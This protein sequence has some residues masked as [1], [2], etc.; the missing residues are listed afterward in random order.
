MVVDTAVC[1][2]YVTNTAN[3]RHQR[4]SSERNEKKRQKE[5]KY[6]NRVF[7]WQPPQLFLN[8]MAG[9]E[10]SPRPYLLKYCARC[11]PDVIDL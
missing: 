4:I 6:N 3:S 9:F 11:H 2:I 5:N 10:T 1:T 8:E 7:L